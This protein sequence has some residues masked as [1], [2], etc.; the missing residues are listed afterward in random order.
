MADKKKTAPKT[1]IEGVKIELSIMDRVMLPVLFPKKGRM[2]DLETAEDIKGKV[3]FS[4]EETAKINLK[5]GESGI[6]WKEGLKPKQFTFSKA[7]VRYLKERY[8]LTDEAGDV[9]VDM[10]SLCR[11]IR[12]IKI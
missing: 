5:Q 1:L 10:V 6:T 7:E 3:K 9:L 12:D 2:A 11:K 8:R 4:A